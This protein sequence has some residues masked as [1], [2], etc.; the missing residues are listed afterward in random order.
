MPSYFE[1][2]VWEE[3]RDMAL[4]MIE[5]IPE[6]NNKAAVGLGALIVAAF[7]TQEAIE[8]GFIA[9]LKQSNL[10]QFKALLNYENLKEFLQS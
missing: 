1:I 3:A 6:K 8:K 7:V 9:D 5:S 10:D 4:T 2:A